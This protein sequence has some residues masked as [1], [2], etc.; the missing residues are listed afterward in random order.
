MTNQRNEAEALAIKLQIGLATVADAVVWADQQIAKEDIPHPLLLD[1]S[2]ASK[3]NF[4]DVA[5]MLRKLPGEA[6]MPIV[7]RDVFESIKHAL[8][9]ESQAVEIGTEAIAT[10]VARSIL[11][12]G[13][14]A[15][16]VFWF[17]CEMDLLATGYSSHDTQEQVVSEGLRHM[18]EAMKEL[19]GYSK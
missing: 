4:A 5:A 16:A 2:M 13:S 18:E 19:E 12:E 6:N 14:F 10:L 8:Q 17:D 15:S 3:H 11:P 7:L 1:V 9:S